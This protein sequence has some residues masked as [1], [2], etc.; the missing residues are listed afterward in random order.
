KY[1]GQRQER[2]VPLNECAAHYRR[3]EGDSAAV[4]DV[5]SLHLQ[6]HIFKG[7]KL[8][9]PV[10]Y[11]IVAK[12]DCIP[13][14]ALHWRGNDRSVPDFTAH[15]PQDGI[16][17]NSSG[18]KPQRPSAPDVETILSEEVGEVPPGPEAR[19]VIG[20]PF[21]ANEGLLDCDAQQDKTDPRQQQ[22]NG[23]AGD[24]VPAQAQQANVQNRKDEPLGDGQDTD[25]EEVVQ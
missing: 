2:R 13:V 4:L 21:S 1:Q 22:S 3:A 5:S 16:R 9:E 6:R 19:R 25:T 17:E 15:P 23:R 18:A 8:Q 7:M 10:D 11:T 24:R 14:E 12:A 20:S